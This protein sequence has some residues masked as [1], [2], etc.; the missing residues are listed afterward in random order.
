MRRIGTW[1]IHRYPRSA[2]LFCRYEFWMTLVASMLFIPGVVFPFFEFTP[3]LGDDIAD[4]VLERLGYDFSP[5]SYSVVGGIVKLFHDGGSEIV[6]AL[7]LLLFS[8][9][10]PL[11]KLSFLWK[12]ILA[13]NRRSIEMLRR[14]ERFGP[15][16]MADVFVV[17]VLLVAFKAWPLGTVF[18]IRVGFFLF[19]GSV[20]LSF[21]ATAVARMMLIRRLRDPADR[22][23]KNQEGSGLS[24]KTADPAAA[25]GG[26]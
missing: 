15:W 16:S 10:F 4:A 17:S 9:L 7:V 25:P 24:E 8:V 11:V 14:L 12:A 19:L 23:P 5:K 1:L 26:A 20:L 22:Q 18:E 21:A 6:I 13:P 2:S 3:S